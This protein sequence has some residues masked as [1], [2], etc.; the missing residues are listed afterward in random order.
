MKAAIIYR[1]TRCRDDGESW[2]DTH[3]YAI[4]LGLPFYF[5]FPK[6]DSTRNL[7]KAAI[8]MVNHGDGYATSVPLAVE[9]QSPGEC[10]GRPGE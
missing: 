2:T 1:C 9:I 5:L 6:P 3:G 7:S 4:T 10:G 8:E